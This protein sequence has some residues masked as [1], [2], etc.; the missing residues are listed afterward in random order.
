MRG[1]NAHSPW[2]DGNIYWDTAGCC[3]GGTHRLSTALGPTLGEWQLITLIYDNGSK[4]IYRGA[5]QIA[6]GSGFLPLTTDLTAFYIGNQGPT[7]D[8]LPN[9][10]YDNFTLWSGALTQA[11]VAVL[12][13]RPVPEPSTV[14]LFGVGSLLATC[15]RRHS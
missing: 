14:V 2:S 1:L 7:F 10:R 11:E 8:L 12:A 9:A 4:S 5:T 3:T 6:S 15:R 13:E